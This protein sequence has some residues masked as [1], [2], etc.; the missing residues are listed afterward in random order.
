[1]VRSVEVEG[2]VSR[3]VLPGWSV[4]VARPVTTSSPVH[5]CVVP[6]TVPLRRS[7]GDTTKRPMHA[8]DCG[9]CLSFGLLLDD[10]AA[11]SGSTS[12]VFSILPAY[13]GSDGSIGYDIQ[14]RRYQRTG[15]SGCVNPA[16]TA[17]Q[18]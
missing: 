2:H 3:R 12:N 17:G 5:A 15:C 11:A 4:V 7:P 6:L 10:V 8:E 9:A 13:F 18:P 16:S 14:R 1:M